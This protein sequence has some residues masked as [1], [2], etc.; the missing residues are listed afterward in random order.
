MASFFGYKSEN[1]LIGDEECALLESIGSSDNIV[2]VPTD[3]VRLE[4]LVRIKQYEDVLDQLEDT[5]SAVHGR[6]FN[7]ELWLVGGDVRVATERSGGDPE[8]RKS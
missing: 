8:H 3:C 7:V 6:L 1:L 4:N 5:K 2:P